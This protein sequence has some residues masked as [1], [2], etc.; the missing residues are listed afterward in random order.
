MLQTDLSISWADPPSA[1]TGGGGVVLGNITPAMDGTAAIGTATTA[2]RADHVHPRDTGKMDNPTGT[3][4]AGAVPVVSANGA[5][6]AWAQPPTDASRMAAPTGTKAAG[7]V[8]AV[9]GDG[10][11]VA[12]TDPPSGTAL[13]LGNNRLLGTDA[14]GNVVPMRGATSVAQS[15]EGAPAVGAKLVFT[16]NAPWP[17]TVDQIAAAIEGTASPSVSIRLEKVTAGTGATLGGVANLLVNSGARDNPAKTTL[18]GTR[19]FAAGDAIR[20]TVTA[21][22]GTIT[23]LMVELTLNRLAG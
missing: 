6:V 2:A 4:T 8:P 21:V 7:R 23:G 9:T 16:S 12:W 20:V 1:G 18:S 11:T 17:G 10:S 19:S 15:F 14:Q 5:A 22:T 13:T 3:K